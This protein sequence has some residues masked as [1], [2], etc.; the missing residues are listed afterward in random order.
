MGYCYETHLHTQE[1]SACASAHAA[2]YID[3]YRERGYAGIITTDHFYHGNCR[4]DRSMPWK[5]WVE[6][7]CRG[8]ELAKEE[9]DRKG[10]PVFFGLEEN[11]QGDE[12]LVYGIT[13]EWLIAHPEIIECSRKKYYEMIH[14]AGGLVVQAHPQRERCYLDKVLLNPDYVDAAEVINIGNEPYMDGLALEYAKQHKLVQT[15]GT[16]MHHIRPEAITS[17]I[18]FERPLS[19]IKDFIQFI[20]QGTGWQLIG[21]KE[22]IKQAEKE[23][24]WENSLPVYQYQ[25]KDGIERWIVK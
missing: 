6:A 5:E 25:N 2:D 7:Y 3:F 4:L 11:F 19:S 16:D 12:Y 18:E 15:A 24:P 13:K 20:K 22:R 8:Y 17:G 21:V 23:K 9:G 10:F 14:A 1:V